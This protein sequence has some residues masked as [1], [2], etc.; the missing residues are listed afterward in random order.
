MRRFALLLAALPFVSLHAR[1]APECAIRAPRGASESDLRKLAKVSARD[2]ESKAVASVAPDKVNSVISGDVDVVEGCLAWT[3][4]LRFSN[5]GGVTE[6]V[7]DAGDGKILSSVYEPP[8]GGA[9]PPPEAAPG[10]PAAPGAAPAPS[11]AA[12][13]VFDPA[14]EE[15]LL[16]KV[17]DAEEAAWNRGDAKGLAAAF[18]DDATYVD[19]FGEVARGRAEVDARIAE[20]LAAWKGTTIAIKVRKVR[21]LK[22]DVALVEADLELTGWKKLPPGFRA[23]D[24]KTQRSRL[25]Q[26]FL[27]EAGAWKVAASYEADVK[28][29]L[30]LPPVPEERTIRGRAR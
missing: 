16:R 28:T 25:L 18:R 12:G 21:V 2:A 8:K 22:P 15:P 20:A 9:A 4:L 23:E 1:A 3:F 19:A 11:P 13:P 17:V 7:V 6:V 14:A 10:V 27:K 29:K 24:D 30:A 5:K 26:V